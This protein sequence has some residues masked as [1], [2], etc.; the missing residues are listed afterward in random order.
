[1]TILI[2][3]LSHVTCVI[4]ADDFS[5]FFLNAR[6]SVNAMMMHLVAAYISTNILETIF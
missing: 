1:M 2:P 5:N 3:S 4:L 6:N